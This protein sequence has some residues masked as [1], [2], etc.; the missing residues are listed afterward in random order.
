MSERLDEIRHTLEVPFQFACKGQMETAEFITLRPPTTRNRRECGALEQAF[1]RA[2]PTSD[3]LTE[4][5]KD[6]AKSTSAEESTEPTGIETVAMIAMSKNS[7]LAET[8][9]IARKLFLSDVAYIN[10]D[11]KVVGNSMDNVSL[12]DFKELVGKYLVGFILR[13]A[14]SSQKKS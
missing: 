12:D 3:G 2:L 4:D 13:S 11:T 10:G 5:Q 7:D 9:E 8:M 6:Q 14:F 1:M